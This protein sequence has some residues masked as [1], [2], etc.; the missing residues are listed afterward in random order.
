MFNVAANV[1][2]HHNFRQDDGDHA[3][4]FAHHRISRRDKCIFPHGTAWNNF[5]DESNSQRAS[6]GT[7]LSSGTNREGINDCRTT[8]R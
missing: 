8:G 2:E 5:I 6:T 7:S 4:V 3:V 1:M